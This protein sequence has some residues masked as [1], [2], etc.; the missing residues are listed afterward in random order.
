MKSLK[1]NKKNRIKQPNDIK[2]VVAIGLAIL[3]FIVALA[4][5]TDPSLPFGGI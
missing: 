4:L 1:P 2:R 5:I 3:F